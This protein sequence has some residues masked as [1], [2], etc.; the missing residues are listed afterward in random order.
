MQQH[1]PAGATSG[2]AGVTAPHLIARYAIDSSNLKAIGYEDGLCVVE[3]HS[4]HLYAY[5]M[6]PEQFEAFATAESKGRYFNQE[7]RGKFT[8]DKLTGQCAGCQLT[9]AVMAEPCPSC[10]AAVR[11]ID[12]VHKEEK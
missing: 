1:R 6:T 10:G 9:P 2:E 12:R 7:I 8:G 4:G 3:F 5:A 11:P